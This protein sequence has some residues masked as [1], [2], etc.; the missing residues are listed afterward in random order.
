MRAL[1]EV[2]TDSGIDVPSTY[3]LVGVYGASA[4]GSVVLGGAYDAGA[5]LVSFVLRLPVSAYGI[6]DR[7]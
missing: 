2:I 3:T 1:R 7:P 4:D 5:K 6:G